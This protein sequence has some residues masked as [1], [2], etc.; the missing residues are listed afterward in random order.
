M[1]FYDYI[2]NFQDGTALRGWRDS[3][4]RSHSKAE[5]ETGSQTSQVLRHLPQIQRFQE[6]THQA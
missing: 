2:S 4:R 5:N 3:S 1:I 6:Q